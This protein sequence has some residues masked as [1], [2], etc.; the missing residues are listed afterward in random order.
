MLSKYID[1]RYIDR[2]W[3]YTAVLVAAAIP[4]ILIAMS[5]DSRTFN[6]INVWIKPL[7]FHLSGVLHLVTLFAVTSLMDDVARRKRLLQVLILTSCIATVFEMAFIDIRAGQ[8]IASHYNYSTPLNA[9]LYALMGVGAVTMILPT[10]YLGVKFIRFGERF[11]CGAGLRLGI[12]IG[13]P[14]AFVLTLVFAGYMSSA[15]SHWTSGQETDAGGLWLFGWSTTGGD[16]RPAHFFALHMMQVV[17]LAGWLGDRWSTDGTSWGVRAAWTTAIFM[18]VLSLYAFF[19][20]L[21]GEAF[22]GVA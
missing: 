9:L 14:A 10:L 21:K 22:I 8:A 12:M 2:Y 20:A 4:F 11:Q 15:G 6:G 1:H 19:Q 3:I 13:F 16:L 5:V 7:K 17:P 18:V